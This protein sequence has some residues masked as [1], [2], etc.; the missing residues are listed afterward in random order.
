[1]RLK[2][3]PIE[4]SKNYKV[5]GWAPVAEAARDTALANKAEPVWDVVEGWLKSKRRI[6]A[7]KLNVP[8]ILNADGNKGVA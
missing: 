8:R 1:M 2:G 4:A 5:A 6:T 3:V 7:R